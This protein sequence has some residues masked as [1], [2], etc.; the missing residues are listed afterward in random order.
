MK[1]QKLSFED[2]KLMA[3]N[4]QSDEIMQQ[5]EGGSLFDCHGFWGRIGK[6]VGN[7]IE[8]EADRAIDRAIDN[9]TN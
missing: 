5:I 4:V 6:A 1:T 2:F 3:N 8:R 7:L 9:L